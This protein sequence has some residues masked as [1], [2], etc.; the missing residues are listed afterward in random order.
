MVACSPPGPAQ[1]SALTFGAAAVAALTV[2]PVTRR[3]A[4]R[5]P[6]PVADRLARLTSG[7]ET[8]PDL[9]VRLTRLVELV[10]QALNRA[11]TSV[12]ATLGDQLTA[13]WSW[14]PRSG[15][16]PDPAP[17]ECLVHPLVRAD[18]RLGS[19]VVRRA[20]ADL[21]PLELRLVA[22]AARRAAVLV[23]SARMDATLHRLVADAE[24]RRGELE[25]SRG[26][27]LATIETERRRIERDIHDGAQQHLV[28]LLVK[29]RLVHVLLDRDPDRARTTADQLRR[30]V[31]EAIE[32]LR[33]LSSGLYPPALADAGP[34]AALQL[35]TT[36][37]PVPVVIEA[38]AGRR[39]PPAMER[40]AYFGCLEAVQNAVK[41]ADADHDPGPGPG[42]RR[43]AGLRGAATTAGASGPR[44][45]RRAP[46]CAGWRTGWPPPAGGWRSSPA[47]AAAPP[48]PG[49][50][51]PPANSRPGRV[52]AGA[53]RVGAGCG[54]WCWPPPPARSP[55]PR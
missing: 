31:R 1:R 32:V 18:R 33:R 45:P 21:S 11:G 50:C 14:P 41:H 22:E 10:G 39:W 42:L 51:R 29:L 5:F 12:T 16:P 40:V 28:A 26:R 30:A 3:L 48:C 34:A 38:E 9:D 13:T 36:G 6:E 17:E 7:Q 54:C 43:G 52:R 35:V 44:R 37:S 47:P 20:P 27:V 15:T 49:G 46:G 25:Q 2:A 53:A 55:R 8:G 4:S 19:L 24:H 23:E